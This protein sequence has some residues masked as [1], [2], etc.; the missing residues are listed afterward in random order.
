M[1]RGVIIMH[2]GDISPP[3]ALYTSRGYVPDKQ[4]EVPPY[5]DISPPPARSAPSGEEGGEGQQRVGA[6]KSIQ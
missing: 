1:I 6:S 3:P 5:T 4:A 2:E